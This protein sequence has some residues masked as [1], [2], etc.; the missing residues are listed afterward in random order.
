MSKGKKGYRCAS[1]KRIPNEG[2]VAVK[3][4]TEEGH[5]CGLKIQVAEVEQPLISTADL[6]AA[7]NRVS[8]EEAGGYIEHLVTGRRI[9]LQRQG[10]VYH[11]KMWVPNGQGFGSPGR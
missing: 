8:L 11:L 6:T 7:G 5:K 3:F 4:L 9:Q 2:E 10:N 1:G